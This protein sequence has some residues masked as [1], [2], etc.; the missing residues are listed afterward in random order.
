MKWGRGEAPAEGGAVEV[1]K[2]WGSDCEWVGGMRCSR[3]GG[4]RD[5]CEADVITGAPADTGRLAC[6]ELMAGAG[7]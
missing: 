7:D 3:A 6:S 2:G 5:A 1:E 4:G